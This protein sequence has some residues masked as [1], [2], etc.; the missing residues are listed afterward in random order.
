MRKFVVGLISVAA[1]LA[2]YLL[3]SLISKTPAFDIDTE[4]E[5]VE[6][7][8]DSNVG[9]FGGEIG[10]I[11]GVGVEGLKNPVYQHRNKNG[12]ID[13]EFGFD[14][15]LY[16]VEDV[17]EVEKPWM[18]V[19]Q[20]SFECYITADKGTTRLETAIG[21]PTPKDATFTGNVVIHIIPAK[22]GKI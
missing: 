13:R 8:T 3:Y 20:R 16:R 4:P 22:G 21:R 14:E 9:E 19:Y 2:I 12:Q 17:W 7:I 18:N 1:V 11:G 6:T 10:K 5:F 15:L